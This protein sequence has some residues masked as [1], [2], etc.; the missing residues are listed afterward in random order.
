MLVLTRK[1]NQS[2]AIGDK[3]VV[4]VTAIDGEQVRLGI[5][6]PRNIPIHR[7]EAYEAIEEANLQ[8]ARSLPDHVDRLLRSIKQVRTHRSARTDSAQKEWFAPSRKH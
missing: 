5:E 6:A 4:T 8:A 3:I 1:V 7:R 2:I